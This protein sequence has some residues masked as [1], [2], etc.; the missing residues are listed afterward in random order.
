MFVN[1]DL[2]ADKVPDSN[3]ENDEWLEVQ[4]VQTR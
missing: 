2:M 4:K 3:G 1:L